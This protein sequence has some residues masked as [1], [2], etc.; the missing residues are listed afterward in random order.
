MR[1]LFGQCLVGDE[2]L[3]WGTLAE[4]ATVRAEGDHE[5]RNRCC[6]RNVVSDKEHSSPPDKLSFET[7][8]H[9]PYGRVYVERSQDI[10][11]QD[12]GGTRID[13]AGERNASL[14]AAAEREALL[15][16]LGSVP[17]VEEADIPLETTLKDD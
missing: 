17:S 2:S 16:N 13:G 14:L 3:R 8:V 11:E 6:Q 4:D 7:F 1:N 12:R 15:A 10:V 5:V 9:D